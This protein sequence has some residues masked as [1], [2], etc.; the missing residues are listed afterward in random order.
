M[1]LAGKRKTQ[2][3]ELPFGMHPPVH[4][5]QGIRGTPP[6][7]LLERFAAHGIQPR[8]AGF[9]MTSG[10]I[11]HVLTVDDFPDQ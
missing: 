10:L 7:G 6:P 9:Q 11:D 1:N 5:Q 8:F 4:P 2:K 3:G